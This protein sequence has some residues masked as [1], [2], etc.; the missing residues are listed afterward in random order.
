MSEQVASEGDKNADLF[1][2]GLGDI[3]RNIPYGYK[4]CF[5]WFA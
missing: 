2:E 4:G 3:I 5:K 1:E